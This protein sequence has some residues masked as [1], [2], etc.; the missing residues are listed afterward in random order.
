MCQ[1]KGLQGSKCKRCAQT[2]CQVDLCR[3]GR[4]GDKLWFPRK[5]R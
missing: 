3:A 2:A 4:I 1:I 5:E